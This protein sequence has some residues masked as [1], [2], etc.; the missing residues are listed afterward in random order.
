MQFE[1]YPYKYGEETPEKGF[2]CSGLV[3]YVYGQFGYPL[4][5]TANDMRKNGLKLEMKDAKPGDILLFARSAGGYFYHCGI[6]LGD[7]TFIHASDETT[8]VTIGYVDHYAY[9][10]VRRLAGVDP[11][12]IEK[13][14]N[15]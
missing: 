2:D 9:T 6:Y 12:E 11:E 4:Y 10:E 8:G 7:G 14:N 3:Y 13:Q 5:R 15:P 1:G